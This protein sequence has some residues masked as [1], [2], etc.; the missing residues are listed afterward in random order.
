MSLTLSIWEQFLT[1]ISA[2]LGT[3]F[4]P[5]SFTLLASDSSV[6]AVCCSTVSKIPARVSC[7]SSGL[8]DLVLPMKQIRFVDGIR[9]RSSSIWKPQD[10]PTYDRRKPFQAIF[11]KNKLFFVL[12]YLFDIIKVI[13]I[14]TQPMVPPLELGG[15]LKWTARKDKKLGG[16]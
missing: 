3:N 11:L 2:A 9:S 5:S 16:M 12:S 8:W 6:D 15:K 14:D 4:P 1:L 7:L 10:S 13:P